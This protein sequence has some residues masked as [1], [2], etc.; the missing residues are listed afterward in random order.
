MTIISASYPKFPKPYSTR[1][2]AQWPRMSPY[3][4][5]TVHTLLTTLSS[6]GSEEGKNK[7]ITAMATGLALFSSLKK[8]KGKRS[9]VREFFFF[10]I[11]LLVCIR[12]VNTQIFLSYFDTQI[13]SLG[14]FFAP[15]LIY[16]NIIVW[17]CRHL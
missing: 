8:E 1:A 17:V 9:Q 11:V 7:T 15:Y 12:F 14:V 10:R 3:T 2:M 5:V 4:N 6:R 13:H 16:C